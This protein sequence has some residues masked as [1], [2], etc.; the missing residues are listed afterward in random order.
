MIWIDFLNN[1]KAIEFVV[2]LS[3]NIRLFRFKN[4]KRIFIQ[5]SDRF[6]NRCA[7]EFPQHCELLRKEMPPLKCAS[8][9]RSS[10]EKNISDV[11]NK[12]ILNTL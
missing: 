4:T 11:V 8:V 5:R 3:K 7:L 10:L 6:Q 12:L 9:G 2:K 1:N